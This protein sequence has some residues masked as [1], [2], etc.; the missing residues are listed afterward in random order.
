MCLPG[1]DVMFWSSVAAKAGAAVKIRFLTVSDIFDVKETRSQVSQ[2]TAGAAGYLK[3]R[4]ITERPTV[5]LYL[6]ELPS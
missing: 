1:I 6:D 4:C 3:K 2:R 5:S